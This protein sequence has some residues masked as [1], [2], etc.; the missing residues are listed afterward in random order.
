M[1]TEGNIRRSGRS[2]HV[3]A[4]EGGGG[5]RALWLGSLSLWVALSA[6][7]AAT[8]AQ[9]SAL[10]TVATRHR[11]CD[12]GARRDQRQSGGAHDRHA[13]R[14]PAGSCLARLG[15]SARDEWGIVLV[16]VARRHQPVVAGGARDVDQ[17][18]GANQAALSVVPRSW[19]SD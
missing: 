9:R 8:S 3:T 4:V 7:H 19:R 16:V 6:S 15:L 12:A 2:G 14:A 13:A 18:R 10:P 11:R 1:A 5:R 17:Q